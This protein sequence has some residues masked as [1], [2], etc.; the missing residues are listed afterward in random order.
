MKRRAFTMAGLALAL[1]GCG[2]IVDARATARETAF[3]AEFPPT[4]QL[5]Q[6]QGRT[7]HV[8][9]RGSGPDLIL[10]HGAS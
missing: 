6:V 3:E 5:I 2:R 8:D 10:L 7:V 1:T 9:I 4:G